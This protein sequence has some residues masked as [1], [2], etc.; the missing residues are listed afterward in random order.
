MDTIRPNFRDFE[1]ELEA[2]QS[3]IVR[4]KKSAEKRMKVKEELKAVQNRISKT[5]R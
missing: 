5:K 2:L 3:T 1:V 4:E